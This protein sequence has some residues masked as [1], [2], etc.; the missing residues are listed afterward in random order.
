MTKGRQY[1][2]ARS[3]KLHTLSLK[4][5]V[6]LKYCIVSPPATGYFVPYRRDQ[7]GLGQALAYLGPLQVELDVSPVLTYW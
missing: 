6:D 5:G 4:L 3:W 1:S 2:L 7:A